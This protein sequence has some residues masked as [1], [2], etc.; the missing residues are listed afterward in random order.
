MVRSSGACGEEFTW[1]QRSARPC[2][3]SRPE[4]L[5][6]FS[7]D[8]LLCNLLHCERDSARRC[9]RV[10]SPGYVRNVGPA[11][12]RGWPRASSDTGTPAAS[13][14][15]HTASDAATAR[16]TDLMSC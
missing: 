3:T 8:G 6:K 7:A 1:D 10:G 4:R 11:V 16:R 13:T 2:S 15:E 9:C 12:V 5:Q 14:C